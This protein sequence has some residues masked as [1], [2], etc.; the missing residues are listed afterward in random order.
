MPK[1]KNSK[2]NDEVVGKKNEGRDSTDEETLTGED[3]I[4]DP[5]II[6]DTFTEE[7]NEYNDVDFL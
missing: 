4:I 2:I 1:K 7:S 6:E 3:A 5:A